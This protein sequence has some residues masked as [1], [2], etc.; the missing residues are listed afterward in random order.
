MFG[1]KATSGAATAGKSSRRFL[2]P[3]RFPHFTNVVCRTT[4]KE[5]KDK[6]IGTIVLVLQQECKGGEI[7][8]RYRSKDMLL[9][10]GMRGSFLIAKLVSSDTIRFVTFYL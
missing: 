9:D 8:A 3:F 2:D 5:D 1:T 10:P 7:A 6:W 4:S